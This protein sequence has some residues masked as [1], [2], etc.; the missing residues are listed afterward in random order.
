MAFQAETSRLTLQRR[1]KIRRRWP[2][3]T[4]PS[5]ELI[6]NWVAAAWAWSTW[7]AG[8]PTTRGRD[9]EIIPAVAN[10]GGRLPGFSARPASS[11]SSTTPIV[12][13]QDV[14]FASSRL[15]FTME[16]VLG[17]NAAELLKQHGGPLPTA[18][19]W[20]SRARRSTPWPTP[21]RA[22]SSTAT[23]SRTTC[24]SRRLIGRDLVK[25]ADFGLA[26]IYQTSPLSGLSLTGQIAGTSGFMAPEQITNFREVK[27][28][29]DQYALAATLY[30]LLTGKK[31]YD[32]PSGFQR[33]VLMILQE[34]PVPI[35]T[36]RAD[37][38]DPLAAVIHRALVRDPAMRFPDA[39]TMRTALSSF[40]R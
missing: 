34:E 32:F 15:F 9:Q 14:G 39:S 22:G 38:P 25:V 27:P 6:G 29:A 21:T 23:S 33:Q 28:P 7:L 3:Q 37:I 8:R 18:L 5:T 40:A 35:R 17:V 11:A 1:L 4:S 19:P 13:F 10:R 31:I 2:C 20:D 24:W 30:Y 12:R 36:R 26:R 16:Y